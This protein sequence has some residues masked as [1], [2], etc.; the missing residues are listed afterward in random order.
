VSYRNRHECK[1]VVPE[2]TAQQALRAVQPFVAPDPH[3]ANSPTHSYPV[4][5]LYLD[6]A[7]RSLYRETVD[8]V[9]QRYKLRVRA[10]ADSPDAPVFLEVKR[11]HDKVVQKLRCPLPRALLADALAGAPLEASDASSQKRATLGEFQRLLTLRRATPAA[12]VRYE[13]QA[14]VGLDDAEVRVTVDRRLCALP[15]DRIELP[16]DGPGFRA[17]PL[18][19][20]ILELKFTDRMPRWMHGVIVANDLHRVSCSK[21]CHSLDALA[22]GQ[23]QVS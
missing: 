13:R 11:R 19:G 22:G 14:Y 3:G 4:V 15:T 16:F 12:V 20:V 5:S 8:G 23:A 6:D 2:A 17:V 9:A 1:F 21:Y 7:R 10:Y 18:P